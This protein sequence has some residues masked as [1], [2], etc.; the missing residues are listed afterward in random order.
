MRS[1]K[2]FMS[3][4]LK[5]NKSKK[6]KNEQNRK[7]IIKSNQIKM[8]GKHG[9]KDR[10]NLVLIRKLSDTRKILKLSD[11]N[12]SLITKCLTTRRCD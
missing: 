8:Q 3:F 11:N 12:K 6:H 5:E 4:L 7:K 1:D 9:N 10:N 2:I